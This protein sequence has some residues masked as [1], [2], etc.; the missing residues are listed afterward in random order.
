MITKLHGV[1]ETLLMTLYFRALETQRQD[2]IIRDEKAIELVEKIDYDFAKFDDWKSQ[3]ALAV[4]TEI[5]DQLIQ[6]FL[7]INPN[8]IIVNL[9][10]GL[11]TRFF[12]LDNGLLQWFEVDLKQVEPVWNDLIGESERHQ[13]IACSVLDFSW[14]DIVSNVHT[15]NQPVLFI[16]EGLFMYL[17][18]DEVKKVI[19]EIKKRFPN[20][21]IVIEILGKYLADNT[22]LHRSVAKT[23]AKFKWGVNDCKELET[24]Q[25]GIHLIEQLYFSDRY[26]HR[27]GWLKFFS[28]LP[29][30]RQQ[31]K[32]GYF[33][34][35]V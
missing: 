34:F 17:S 21:E 32:A 10:A 24:W 23:N 26:R 7:Q 35:T 6:K 8:A 12:R 25:P 19:L 5:F 1:S 3:T 4:R 30:F 14:M 22:H 31:G 27:Q 13:F 28:Y 20:S 16:A 33:K 15:D 29:F 9:G 11:C 2:A 18:E